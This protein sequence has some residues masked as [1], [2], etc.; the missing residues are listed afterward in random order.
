M[1]KDDFP[2]WKIYQQF[3]VNTPKIEAAGK[4][5]MGGAVLTMTGLAVPQFSATQFTC[6]KTATEWRA[7][8]LSSMSHLGLA[9]LRSG[10]MSQT[11]CYLEHV[12]LYK[13]Y[14]NIPGL[15]LDYDHCVGGPDKQM[16]IMV[17]LRQ[18]AGNVRVPGLKQFFEGVCAGGNKAVSLD[19]STI[20]FG[21]N[22]QWANSGDYQFM[23]SSQG[24]FR[25]VSVITF[26]DQNNH[27]PLFPVHEDEWEWLLQQLPVPGDVYYKLSPDETDPCSTKKVPVYPE[28]YGHMK[29]DRLC[30]K[31][32]DLQGDNICGKY[33]YPPQRE[34]ERISTTPPP[35]HKDECFDCA[36]DEMWYALL[37]TFIVYWGVQ[38]TAR[39]C[40]AKGGEWY[41]TEIPPDG[42][43][44][45]MTQAK[46]FA[47]YVVAPSARAW[48]GYFISAFFWSVCVYHAI[49]VFDWLITTH[50]I[51]GSFAKDTQ[52][53]IKV[54]EWQRRAADKSITTTYSDLGYSNIGNAE[55]SVK[56]DVC[57]LRLWGLILI[58]WLAV[59]QC[60]HWWFRSKVVG[61]K[62]VVVIEEAAVA[63][64]AADGGAMGG[65]AGEGWGGG[66]LIYG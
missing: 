43:I 5:V 65:K 32:P 8:T 23:H 54:W 41:Y 29:V 26:L 48:W 47:D 33:C 45:R 38:K 6:A 64:D 36:W 1:E 30:L 40:R 14:D 21:A 62:K 58:T 57:P 28:V 37:A 16:T 56:N 9:T 60:M 10:N 11:T 7:K 20:P 46:R 2:P 31:F 18:V 44:L 19:F 52:V 63:M 35:D 13:T 4:E 15:R 3:K 12:T 34:E 42:E 17:G 24:C 27:F 66:S 53:C 49:N 22:Y 39:L 61:E 59:T 25:P 55:V 51:I 50:L